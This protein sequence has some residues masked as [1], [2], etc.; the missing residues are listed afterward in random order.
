MDTFY[1]NKTVL[2]KTGAILGM[3]ANS[4]GSLFKKGKKVEE[5]IDIISES[6]ETPEPEPLTE[7][8]II[9]NIK[10]Q[11]NFAKVIQLK[12]ISTQELET[13]V[14]KLKEMVKWEYK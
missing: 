12:A 13:V 4:I 9:N 14:E 1:S 5:E 10:S 8:E 11:S 7:Q 3:V 2:V 6:D